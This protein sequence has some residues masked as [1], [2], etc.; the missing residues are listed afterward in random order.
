MKKIRKFAPS[1]LTMAVLLGLGGCSEL[2]ANDWHTDDGSP[3]E[4]VGGI[5]GNQGGN[6]DM[7][8]MGANDRAS[9]LA[10]KRIAVSRP[11]PFD[12]GISAITNII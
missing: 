12:A 10:V 2:S 9:T 4:T 11:L 5:T 6:S 8:S 1:T 7:V 3:V